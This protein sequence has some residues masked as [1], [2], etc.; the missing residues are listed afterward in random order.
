MK[1]YAE[2][3]ISLC[4]KHMQEDVHAIR[5]ILKIQILN[6]LSVFFLEILKGFLKDNCPWLTDLN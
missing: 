6:T 4:G 5:L 3:G 1:Y 2:F